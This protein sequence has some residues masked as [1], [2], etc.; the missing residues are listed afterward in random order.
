M[1]RHLTDD[2]FVRFAQV[3]LKAAGLFAGVVGGNAG[4]LTIEA[5]EKAVPLP[6][7][8]SPPEPWIAAGL[9]T[10]G[11]H[12]T[13]DNAR[14]RA[15]LKRDGATLGD[16]DSLPWCGDWTATAKRIGLPDEDLPGPL[17]E[18]PYWARN[19]LHFGRRL[20]DPMLHCVVVFERGSGGHV[21]FAVGED[22]QDLYVLG[23]NQGDGVSVTRIS[24]AR[25]LGARWPKTWPHEPRPLPRMT[26]GSIPASVNEF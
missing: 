26:P 4:P 20:E 13:R 7:D 14:L 25:L 11:W 21:G 5:F 10:L 9:E 18:N 15:W 6:A 3:R 16:P 1:T 8:L 17:G 23:G 19:W 24:K 12:E 2:E 22:D